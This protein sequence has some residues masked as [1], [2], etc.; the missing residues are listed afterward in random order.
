MQIAERQK[1]I[2]SQFLGSALS[3]PQSAIRIFCR[4]FT[5]PG[6]PNQLMNRIRFRLRVVSCCVRQNDRVSLGMREIEC[7]AEDVAEFVVQ[8]HTYRS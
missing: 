6:T 1:S 2:T 3:I 4:R 5:R 8:R 7:S